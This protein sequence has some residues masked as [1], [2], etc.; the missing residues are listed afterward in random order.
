MVRLRILG[1]KVAARHIMVFRRGSN[2]SG[3]L[4]LKSGRIES[5][6]K[7]C[8]P[9]FRRG[10]RYAIGPSRVVRELSMKS[11]V[12]GEGSRRVK[13]GRACF[14]IFNSCRFECRSR[15]ECSVRSGRL[16]PI[17]NFFSVG[18]VMWGRINRQ[19]GESGPSIAKLRKV[20]GEHVMVWIVHRTRGSENAMGVVA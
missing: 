2:R 7:L 5:L 8:T 20:N 13:P 9:T 15:N 1:Q 18:T 16:P 11:A 6:V 19:H 17:C 3:V 4:R 12:V 14:Q 10:V